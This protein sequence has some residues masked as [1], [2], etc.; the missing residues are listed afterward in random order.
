MNT[1]RFQSPWWLLAFGLWLAVAILGLKRRRAAI[2]FSD[3]RILDKF[4]VTWAQ[5]C[6]RCLPWLR[7]GG[8]ALLIIALARPQFGLEEFRIR[9]EGIVIQMCMDRSGSMQA[10]DFTLDGEQVNRLEAVKH[11]FRDFVVGNGQLPGRPDD[12]IGLIAFG[13][14]AESKSPATLDHGALLQILD[15]I[16]LPQPVTDSHGNVINEALLEQEL[17]TAIGDAIALAC[18]RLQNAKAKSKVIIL[19]S[20]GEN[21]AGVIEPRK[22]AELAKRLGIKIYTIGVGTT[23]YAPFPVIDPFGRRRQ[24]RQMVR[25]DDE[26]LRALAHITGGKYFNAQSSDALQ[27]VYQEIDSLEKTMTEGALYTQYR[28]MF[29]RLLWPGIALVLVEL[30]LSSTRFRSLP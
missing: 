7:L 18:D 15:T 25:L 29:A 5:R 28:E 14:F 23:G 16:Q 1:F 30:V 19:L 17:A 20:D 9:A 8:I 26:T 22:A 2:L 6:K 11:A 4:P 12:Q 3:V 13:G 21:T 10:M 27:Q 24:V